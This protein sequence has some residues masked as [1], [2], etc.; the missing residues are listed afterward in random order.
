MLAD[1]LVV[2]FLGGTTDPPRLDPGAGMLSRPRGC[3]MP[4][5]VKKE[6]VGTPS[7]LDEHPVAHYP[8]SNVKGAEGKTST[9]HIPSAAVQRKSHVR[10]PH[11]C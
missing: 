7:L 2:T 5:L 1:P 4:E 9:S 6:K 3:P 11:G 8:A 10:A